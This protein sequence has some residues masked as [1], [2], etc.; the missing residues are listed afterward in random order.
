MKNNH[1]RC[2]RTE[3]TKKLF[4]KEKHQ[5]RRNWINQKKGGSSSVQKSK[6]GIWI[7]PWSNTN[8][9]TGSLSPDIENIHTR[10]SIVKSDIHLELAPSEPIQRNVIGTPNKSWILQHSLPLKNCSNRNVWCNSS[11]PQAIFDSKSFHSLLSWSINNH[12]RA[13]VHRTPFSLEIWTPLKP[14]NKND[15]LIGARYIP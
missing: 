9:S 4:W 10:S 5:N 8:D 2:W 11:T 1:W 12:D 13:T 6:L 3:T 15:A 14:K 7:R